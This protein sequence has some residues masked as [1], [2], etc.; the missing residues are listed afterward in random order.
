LHKTSTRAFVGELAQRELGASSAE[1][2]FQL[3]YDLPASY[4]FHKKAV[5]DIEVDLWRFQIPGGLS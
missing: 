5:K 4:A 3:R 2:L 1:V